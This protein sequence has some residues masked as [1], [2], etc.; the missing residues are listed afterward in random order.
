MFIGG[1]EFGDEGRAGW[2]DMI[3]K[4]GD[5]SQN[6]TASVVPATPPLDKGPQEETVQRRFRFQE[7][8]SDCAPREHE[9]VPKLKVS[10]PQNYLPGTVILDGSPLLTTP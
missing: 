4:Y 7:P 2:Q 6:V 9:L 10:P 1:F 8:R 5:G 3:D